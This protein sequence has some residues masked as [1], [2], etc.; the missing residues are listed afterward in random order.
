MQKIMEFLKT[1]NGLLLF[2]FEMTLH[3]DMN[4]LKNKTY[5]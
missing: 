3:M 5:I 4:I 1:E 2:L